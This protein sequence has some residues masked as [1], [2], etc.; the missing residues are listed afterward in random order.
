[1]ANLVSPGYERSALINNILSPNEERVIEFKGLNRRTVV[2]EGEMSEMTNLTADNYPVLSPRKLRGTMSLPEGVR[3]PVQILSRFNRIAMIAENTQGDVN[4]YYDGAKIASVTGLT[5]NSSMVAINTKVCFFPNKTYLELIKSGSNVTIGSFGNLESTYNL[6]AVSLTLSS[7][8]VR[9][10]LPT[11]HGFGYDDAVNIVGAMTYV[12]QGGSSTTKAVNVSCIIEEVISGTTTDTIV[13]PRETFIE[14]TG[15]GA[16]DITIT[17][18][19]SRTMPDLDH[20]IE[21]N[22]RLWGACNQDNTIYACKLGDPKNWQYFQGTGLDSY[23]A[24]QG[25]DGNW[26]GVAG[27]SGHIIFFKQNSMTRIYGTAPSNY[28]VSNMECYGVEEGSRQSVVV[29]NDKVLYKST[30]GI[31]AYDGGIPY[32]VS[33]KL[34]TTYKAAVAGTEGA[35]YYVAMQR[36]GGGIEVLVLDIDKA[37]WHREDNTKFRNCCTSGNS[38]YFVTYDGDLVVCSPDTICSDWLLCGSSTITGHV[39]IINPTVVTESYDDMEWMAQFGPFDEFIE[40]RK[41]YSKLSLRFKVNGPSHVKVYIALNDGEW[42]MVKDFDPAVTEG[43][44]IPIIPRRCDRYSV[45]I[46]GTGNCEIKSLT[47]RVRAGTGLKL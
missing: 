32:L 34:N 6:S 47:R 19:M 25:T 39:G 20:V 33:E 26:T 16:T 30:I 7:E 17:A 10:S 2:E 40:N 8:D 9:M 29:I 12:P 35:K 18:T 24:Q 27:Y 5:F 38:L 22:N 13:L 42:E 36:K 15:E 21:W 45:R 28:Q 23:Y 46:E 14:L 3:R 31:M 43:H 4:F 1:M 41:I 11:G 44:F 37:V